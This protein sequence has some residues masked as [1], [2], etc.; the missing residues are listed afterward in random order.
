MNV[1]DIWKYIASYCTSNEIRKLSLLNTSLATMINQTELYFQLIHPMI[2]I[3]VIGDCEME[4]LMDQNRFQMKHST[5]DYKV[6]EKQ[7]FKEMERNSN[8]K[9]YTLQIHHYRDCDGIV[10]Y[11]DYRLIIVPSDQIK[12]HQTMKDVRSHESFAD[13][14][15]LLD[16]CQRGQ[17]TTY[18]TYLQELLD[19]NSNVQIQTYFRDNVNHMFD[20]LASFSLIRKSNSG[21]EKKSTTTNVKNCYDIQSLQFNRE[22]GHYIKK[23]YREFFMKDNETSLIRVNYFLCFCSPWFVAQHIGFNSMNSKQRLNFIRYFFN[24]CVF[25]DHSP[26]SFFEYE[27]TPY[28][29]WDKMSD[30]A[31]TLF[32]KYSCQ[33]PEYNIMTNG[34]ICVKFNVI[35]E[36]SAPTE[37]VIE[38]PIQFS[39]ENNSR[40]PIVKTRSRLVTKLQLNKRS[41]D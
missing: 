8:L 34:S 33:L 4:E 23:Q 7:V 13:Q 41:I 1:V 21:T 29:C 36:Q 31:N 39:S 22:L 32:E 2:T 18:S 30:F 37:V 11:Y 3:L 24:E 25:P 19:Y 14:I 40:I 9:R 17:A 20:N 10:A 27:Y 38:F 16:Y 26:L 12:R 5:M 6:Y 35:I 28:Y 15:V